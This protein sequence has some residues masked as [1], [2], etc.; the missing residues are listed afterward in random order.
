MGFGCAEAH[1]KASA[2]VA[3][4]LYFAVELHRQGKLVGH[5]KLLGETGKVLKA[6]RRQPGSDVADYVL[7]LTPT[8][9]GAGLYHL[10]LDVAVPEA[11]G[12]SEISL[13]HGEVRK[14]ELGHKPGDL[15]VT[16]TLM[17]VDSP[18]FRTLMQL[19]RESRGRPGAI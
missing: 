15:A 9:S 6:E 3:R 17:E 5:P 16:L 8:Q 1:R 10:D 18:E 2:P 12:H 11:V 19:M 14:L 7:M 4:K 13:L